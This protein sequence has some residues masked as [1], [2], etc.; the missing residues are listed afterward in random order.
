MKVSAT[1]TKEQFISSIDIR[2]LYPFLKTEQSVE[3]VK[4]TIM[5]SEFK[6]D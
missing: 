4:R 3:A 2:A 1:D 5:S 6:L